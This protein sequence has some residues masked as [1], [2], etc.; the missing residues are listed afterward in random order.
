MVAVHAERDVV[1]HQDIVGLFQDLGVGAGQ[2]FGYCVGAV[3]GG[4]LVV[5][6]VHLLQVRGEAAWHAYGGELVVGQI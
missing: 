3:N 6:E 2:G 1:H 5:R 4:E